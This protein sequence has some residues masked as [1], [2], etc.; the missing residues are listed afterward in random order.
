MGQIYLMAQHTIIYLGQSTSAINVAFEE[1]AE[2][3]KQSNSWNVICTEKGEGE[4]VH[5]ALFAPHMKRVA[6]KLL[7]RPWF[8]RIW[9]FQELVLS[10]TPWV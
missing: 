4:K 7:A 1:A 8:S 3:E 5:K 2:L 9:V 6:G 10:R